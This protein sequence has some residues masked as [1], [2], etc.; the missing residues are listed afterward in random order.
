MKRYLFLTSF[1]LISCITTRS[2]AQWIQVGSFGGVVVSSIVVNDGRLFVGTGGNGV[3]VS[4]N[5]G[6]TWNPAGLSGYSVTSLA[7]TDTFLFAGTNSIPGDIFRSSNSGSTWVPSGLTNIYFQCFLVNSSA[8]FAGTLFTYPGVYRTTDNGWNWTRVDIDLPCDV[9]ALANEDTSFLF[10]GTYLGVFLSTNGGRNWTTVNTGL[11]SLSVTALAIKDS[12]LFAG[13]S[14]A[15]VF[16]STNNGESW[17]STNNGLTIPWVTTFA[18]SGSCIFAATYRSDLSPADVFL[19]T[20]NGSSWSSTNLLVRD[21]WALAVSEPYLF[22]GGGIGGVYRRPLAEM[23]TTIETDHNHILDHPT[24]EQNYPN[25]FNPATTIT[26]QL[27]KQSRVL[28][29]VFDLLGREIATLVDGM[30]QAGVRSVQFDAGMLG[31]G[32]YFY[33]LETGGFLQTRKLLLLK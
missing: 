12:L 21:V 13:T 25:P 3:F 5:N 30:E 6:T 9:R 16:V 23:I 31:S 4:N 22:A 15:G 33:R 32:V 19:S 1:L 8:I 10:A 20:N 14:D 11:S 26:F 29:R 17:R 28:L 24:L 18:Q 2:F 27:P 7:A